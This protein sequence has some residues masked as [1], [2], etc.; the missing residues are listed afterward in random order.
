MKEPKKG[1]FFSP[2]IAFDVA[3]FTPLIFFK[4]RKAAEQRV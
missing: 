2:P 3:V 4:T 1:F